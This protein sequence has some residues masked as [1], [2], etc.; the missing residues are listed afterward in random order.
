MPG[1]ESDLSDPES[2]Q[3][4]PGE[5][6]GVEV[7]DSEATGPGLNCVS[8]VLGTEFSF[9]TCLFIQERS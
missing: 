9:Q 5:L 3:G 4:D 7:S 1:E 2:W 8:P 6:R